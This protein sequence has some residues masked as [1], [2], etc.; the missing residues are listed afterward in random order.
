MRDWD[1]PPFKP[2]SRPN[3]SADHLIIRRRLAYALDAWQRSI[4]LLDVMRQR[5][6]QYREYSAQTAPHVLN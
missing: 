1:R 4:L 6:E 3:A 2:R 5:G